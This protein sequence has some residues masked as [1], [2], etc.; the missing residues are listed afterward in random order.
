MRVFVIFVIS[1]RVFFR[2]FWCFLIAFVMLLG[3]SIYI[4][5][6]ISF[7]KITEK[8]LFFFKKYSI[9]YNIL[10]IFVYIKSIEN[11]SYFCNL[12]FSVGKCLT[13]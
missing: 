4:Y 2:R 9:L 8:L 3:K 7:Q 11:N 5:T 10:K 12:A 13:P 6:I 1:V